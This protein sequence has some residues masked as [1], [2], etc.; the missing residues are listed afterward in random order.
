MTADKFPLDNSNFHILQGRRIL[1]FYP[2]F[3]FSGAERQGFYLAKYLKQQC[4]MQVEFWGFKD[5]GPL[6]NLCAQENIPWQVVPNPQQGSLIR[7]PLQLVRYAARIRSAH[8]DILMPYMLAPCV[9][10]GSIAKLTGAVC[11]WNQRDEGRRGRMNPL[12]EA[13]AV[14]GCTWFISNSNIGAQFLNQELHAPAQKISVIY[15]GVELPAPAASREA[16]RQRLG[17][18]LQDFAACMLA[19]LTEHKD[20]LTLVSA[21]AEVVA[22]T[23]NLNRQAILVL[24]GYHGSTAVAIQQQIQSLH[25]DH[26]VILP[27]QVEDVSGLLAAMDLCVHSS[28]KEGLPNGILEAMLMGLP[29]VATDIPGIREALGP[30]NGDYLVPSASPNAFAGKIVELASNAGLMASIGARNRKRI[31]E[32]FSPDQYHQATARLLSSIIRRD[33]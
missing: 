28:E 5:P 17:I 19:N 6:S 22:Q 15:N 26:Y 32:Q 18:G 29:V 21:W 2:S 4:D 25:L 3:G 20:Q 13:A 8:A 27:G 30:D 16:W 11:I 9:S 7:R 23:Q 24:A 10:V 31:I 12:Q 33:I 1:F 14:R